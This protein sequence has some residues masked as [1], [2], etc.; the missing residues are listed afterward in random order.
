MME[1][2]NKGTNPPPNPPPPPPPHGSNAPTISGI[3]P[4]SGARNVQVTITGTNYGTDT[5]KIKVSFNGV[6]A[7]LKS[8]SA[9]Q[10]VTLVPAK[11][12][13]GPV[14]VTVDGQ[15]VQGP[16][17]NYLTS[18]W[19]TTI[20]GNGQSGF[21]DGSGSAATF[22]SPRGITVDSSGNV[23]VADWGNH[24]IRKITPAGVVTTLAGDPN[25]FPGSANGTGSSASFQNPNDITLDPLHGIL[26]VLDASTV[27]GYNNEIRNVTLT[28]TVTYTGDPHLGY[29]DG[30]IGSAWFLQPFYLNSDAQGNVVVS[31]ATN[32]RIRMISAAGVVSTLAGNGTSGNANGPAG[33]A[34]VGYVYGITT[35]A[36]GNIYF[37][38]HTSNSIRKL[39]GGQVTTLAGGTAGPAGAGG[40]VDGTGSAAQFSGPTGIVA[41]H[42][43]N[44]YVA[45]IHN[46]CIRKI[47][48]A[49][50]VT[51][52][53]GKPGPAGAG[54]IDGN[55]S[56]ARF[57]LPYGITIDSHGN[58][59]V[60]DYG[61][62]AI[63]K[64]SFE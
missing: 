38:E 16:I 12:G 46:L 56:D 48:P 42:Q 14:I 31:D 33:G 41:D 22:Y 19:V 35:D 63:R 45:D 57:D 10:I 5:S 20:A 27:G 64:I 51:T 54:L 44:I 18:V 26:Y 34:T 32:F 61:N 24:T 43:G 13:K 49:G 60:A 37:T 7:I 47:T 2:C 3:S 28:G 17:F 21:A 8:A 40:Y 23:Y 55:A 30:N 1:A 29:R 59:Y 52:I 62:N 6:A 15:S 58:L 11:A 9:T 4:D 39:A 25:G 36:Q 53:A 50:V